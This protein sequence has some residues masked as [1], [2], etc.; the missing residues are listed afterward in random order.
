M[1][2]SRASGVVSSFFSFFWDAGFFVVCAVCAG[3][4]PVPAWTMTVKIA[5]AMTPGTFMPSLKLQLPCRCATSRA[6]EF[7][8][9]HNALCPFSEHWNL[10]ASNPCGKER[11][12]VYGRGL[13]VMSV[14]S[15][16]PN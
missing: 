13:A 8:A 4:A 1:N 10:A 9:R 2:A 16:S 5:A 7:D 15:D 14:R 3:D 6:Q 12:I 11:A